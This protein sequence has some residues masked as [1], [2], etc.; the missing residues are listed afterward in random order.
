MACFVLE[1]VRDLFNLGKKKVGSRI[2]LL[3]TAIFVLTVFWTYKSL[4]LVYLPSFSVTRSLSAERKNCNQCWVGEEEWVGRDDDDDGLQQQGEEK[5]NCTEK[6]KNLH[7][8][9]TEKLI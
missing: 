3:F 1:F 7:Y 5:Q 9:T 2:V 8:P 6:L 4:F